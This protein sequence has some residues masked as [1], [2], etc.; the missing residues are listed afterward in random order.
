MH[1][2]KKALEKARARHGGG[3]IVDGPAVQWLGTQRGPRF[4]VSDLMATGRKEQQSAQ[5]LS[6]YYADIKRYRIRVF[7]GP[8]AMVKYFTTEG[9]VKERVKLK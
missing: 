5:L 1:L 3:N 8:E 7:A 9:N 2:G 6:N 4:L